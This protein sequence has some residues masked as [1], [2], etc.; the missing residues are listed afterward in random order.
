MQTLPSE[1]VANGSK[2]D[3]LEL[4]DTDDPDDAF[5]DDYGFVN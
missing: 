1:E 4:E 2:E 5:V 3:D